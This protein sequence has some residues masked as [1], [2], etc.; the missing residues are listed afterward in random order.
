[1][2]KLAV[3][4]LCLVVGM[5]A[6]TSVG[7]FAWRQ[8]PPPEVSGVR[9]G[10][11]RE[12]VRRRLEKIGRL[13]K[14]ERKQQ[15]VWRLRRDPH[16]SHLIIGFNKDYSQVRYL[17]AT[18]REDGGG[19]RVRYADVLDLKQARRTG[20]ANN[21]RYTQEVAARGNQPGYVVSARGTDAR[22]LTYY[23]IEKID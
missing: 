6:T 7:A 9:I 21:Y 19:R 8:P 2:K 15:E 3:L 20:S 17:T 14:E 23:S 5:L 10:M 22:Y 13:E 1:M 12:A 16:Y 11:S 18:A 4:L